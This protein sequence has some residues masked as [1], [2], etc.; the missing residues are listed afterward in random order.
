MLT[1][2]NNLPNCEYL[3]VDEAVAHTG[4]SQ[5][6]ILQEGVAVWERELDRQLREAETAGELAGRAAGMTF[7]APSD[8]DVARFL[9]VYNDVAEH[10]ARLASRFDID[11]L[12]LFRYARGVVAHAVATGEIDCAGERP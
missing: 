10:N 1:L 7:T 11:G 3:S 8:G 5:R 2:I 9:G 6:A 12:R 4:I